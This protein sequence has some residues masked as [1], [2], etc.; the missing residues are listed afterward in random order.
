MLARSSRG[1]MFSFVGRFACV[2]GVRSSRDDKD[3]AATWSEG[4]KV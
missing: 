2:L 1:D 3:R 4:G